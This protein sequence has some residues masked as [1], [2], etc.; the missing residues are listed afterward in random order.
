[1]FQSLGICRGFGHLWVAQFGHATNHSG[2]FAA[3]TVNGSAFFD[4]FII[5]RN[6][7]IALIAFGAI[8]LLATLAY[9]FGYDQAAFFTGGE[10]VMKDS[11]IPYRDFI[12]TK[13]PVIFYLYGFASFL[14][15]HNTWGIRLLDILWQ[16]GTAVYFYRI[17]KEQAGNSSVAFLASFF[18]IWQ[19]S[20]SGFWMT[21][22]AE[23]FAV[24]P[25]LAISHLTLKLSKGTALKYGLLAGLLL[26]VIFL[27]KFTLVLFILGIAIFLFLR[28]RQQAISFLFSLA[29]SFL[30]AVGLYLLHLHLAGALPN[31]IEGLRWVREYAALSPL[32]NAAT[33]GEEYHKLFPQLL[34]TSFSTALTILGIFGIVK[35]YREKAFKVDLLLVMLLALGFAL[36]GVLYERKFFPYHYA[37]AF[38]FFTPFAAI[39]VLQFLKGIQETKLHWIVRMLLLGVIFFYS[40]FVRFFSQTAVYSTAA[41]TGKSREA[42]VQQK[43]TNYYAEDQKITGNYLRSQMQS[44]DRLF[45]WGN[46]VG[47]YYFANRLPVTFALTNTPFITSWTSSQWKNDLI[48]QL[49]KSD[50]KYIVIEW[51]DNREYI[52]GTDLDSYQHMM[53]WPELRDIVSTRYTEDNRIG[54]FLIYRRNN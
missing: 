27:L 31:F 33:V 3:M 28:R 10:M 9:P 12:D 32:L 35:C 1:M 25:S 7:R 51:G 47:V 53:V 45:F 20:C 49:T 14:F 37:R 40:P 36:L 16:F 43:I 22:Q 52:S 18:Y 4:T 29:A 41:L 17:L 48:G 13:P 15:G 21:A 39:G 34:F 54:H 50:P 5:D 24:L 23:S 19:Y 2:I 26:A 42:I 6:W 38:V 8:S 46:G 44:E 11:A 30:V